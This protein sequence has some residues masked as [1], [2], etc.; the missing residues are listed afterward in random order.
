M[1]TFVIIAKKCCEKGTPSLAGLTLAATGMPASGRGRRAQQVGH[2]PHVF[3]VAAI[4]AWAAFF[5]MDRLWYH[6]LLRG[7][8]SH[9]SS[10]ENQFS[11]LIPGI[12]LPNK[13]SD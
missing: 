2:R 1:Q 4:F 12:G 3:V 6:I 10:L 9:A 8:V 7:A 11:G 5:F 13:I